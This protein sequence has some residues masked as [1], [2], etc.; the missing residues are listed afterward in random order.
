METLVSCTTD[1]VPAMMGK[2]TGVIKRP[3]CVAAQLIGNHCCLHRQVLSSKAMLGELVTTLDHIVEAIDA[4]K[5]TAT[6]SRLFP[7]LCEA[8]EISCETLLWLSR[9]KAGLRVFELRAVIAELLL[10]KSHLLTEYFLD[11]HFLEMVTYIADMFSAL[12]AV[13]ASLQGRDT[14]IFEACNKL[15]AFPEKIKLWKIRVQRGQLEHFYNF[16]NFI[17][18]EFIK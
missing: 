10:S 17:E 9:G 5:S 12:C 18:A 8:Q 13:N 16:K 15:C 2:R 11:M 3:K 4:I 1:G 7:E 6:N 14:V